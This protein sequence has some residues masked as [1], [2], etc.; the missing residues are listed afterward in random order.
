[1]RESCEILGC[2]YVQWE[3]PDNTPDWERV[4]R[5]MGMLQPERVW[6][7]LPE[8]G[9]HPHHNTIG[10]MALDLFPQT[11]F[12]STY[13]HK[14]GKTTSGELVLPEPGWEQVKRDAMA[15]YVSQANHPNTTAGFTEWA[16]DEY[17]TTP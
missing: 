10:Q 2:D 8:P 15:C 14:Y 7:P 9:G 17:L 11:V 5:D 6:A 4:K 13:T 12:Y 1:M 3:H 16:I